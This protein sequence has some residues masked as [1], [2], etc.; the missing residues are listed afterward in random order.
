MNYMSFNVYPCI[1]NDSGNFAVASI[2]K[3]DAWYKSKS[4]QISKQTFGFIQSNSKQVHISSD[5]QVK[6]QII[7]SLSLSQLICYRFDNVSA[8]TL[9]HYISVMYSVN[10]T[11]C[12]YVDAQMLKHD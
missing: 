5:F 7:I 12:V 1:Q 8:Y 10:K 4:F 11:N 9:I 6:Y 3:K 2:L